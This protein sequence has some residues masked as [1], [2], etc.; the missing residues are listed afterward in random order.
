MS[1]YG[2]TKKVDT[3]FKDA[4]EKTTL[5]LQK[6]GFWVLTTIDVTKTMEVK[7]WKNMEQ[8]TILWACN[9][10]LAFEAIENEIEVWLLLPCNVIIY[11]NNWKVFVSTIIPSIAMSLAKNKLLENIASK[12]EMKLKNAIDNI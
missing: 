8:Y 12:A 4:I 7:L 2:Y 11:K 9:P 5:S 10:T 1:N 3:T 6:E